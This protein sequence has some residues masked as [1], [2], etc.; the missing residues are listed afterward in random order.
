MEYSYGVF[1]TVFPMEL[2][3]LV[4]RSMVFA[5]LLAAIHTLSRVGGPEGRYVCNLF[6][7]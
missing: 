4:Y 6:E 7:G 2:Y 1:C 5:V 3:L